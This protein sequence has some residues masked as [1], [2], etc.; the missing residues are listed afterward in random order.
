MSSNNEMAK[1]QQMWAKRR[2]D[3]SAF[4]ARGCVCMVCD[5]N[6]PDGET[7]WFGRNKKGRPRWNCRA[8]ERHP[9]DGN[10]VP[11]ECEGCGRTVMVSRY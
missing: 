5:K 7:V 10:D 8:C 4:V 9:D 11:L 3:W 1:W 6:I 2:A